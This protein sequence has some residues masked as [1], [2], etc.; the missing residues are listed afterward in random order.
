M[1]QSKKTQQFSMREWIWLYGPFIFAGMVFCVC[2]VIELLR[3]DLSPEVRSDIYGIG[4][5][6]FYYFSILLCILYGRKYG[7]NW[8][9]CVIYSLASFLIVFSKVSQTWR[10]LDQQLLGASSVASFRSILLLP[11]LCF[12]LSGF[13]SRSTLTLCDYLTPYYFFQHGITTNTCWMEGCCAGRPMSWGILSPQTGEI[14]FPAQPYAVILALGVS[15]WGLLYARK[16]S[17]RTNGE[18]FSGILIVYGF[19]RFIME[20]FTDDLRVVGPFSLYSFYALLLMVM[21]IGVR[22]YLRRSVGQTAVE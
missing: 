2:L 12:A 11:V 18:V 4:G 3:V 22:W 15:L 21:G 8:W 7:L 17:Y 14:V 13:D 5:S 19:F 1:N 9:R 10:D 20:F 16:H 6:V